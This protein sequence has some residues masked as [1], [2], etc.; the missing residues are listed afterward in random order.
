MKSAHFPVRPA[1]ACLTI[2]GAVLVG[3]PAASGALPVSGA[4]RQSQV[5]NQSDIQPE[6]TSRL[7]YRLGGI[8]ATLESKELELTFLAAIIP[9]HQAAIDMA[10][11][12]L[13]R[14]AD[15]HIRSHARDIINGQ[16]EQIDLFT[17]WLEQWYGLSPDQAGAQAPPEARE[18]MAAM[19]QETQARMQQLANAPGGQAFDVE[20]VRLMIPHHNGGIIEFLEPQSRAVHA[21][22][23]DESASGIATQE[24]EVVDF[25]QWLRDNTRNN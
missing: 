3:A 2:A 12:E 13:E 16:Q 7:S 21:K 1:I 10:E 15:N 14:G 11:M 25:R 4:Y 8:L 17:R 19:E 5:Q 24:K 9:H 18:V 20:F 22:L 6:A 23:R